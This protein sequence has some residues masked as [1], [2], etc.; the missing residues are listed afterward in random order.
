[1]HKISIFTEF[2]PLVYFLNNEFFFT[3]SF[4][5]A[6]NYGMYHIMRKL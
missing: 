6:E 3:F 2:Y 5:F 1:M 4:F